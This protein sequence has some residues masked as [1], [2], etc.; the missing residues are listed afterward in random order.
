MIENPYRLV[1]KRLRL[2]G[3]ALSRT[4]GGLASSTITR[5]EQGLYEELSAGMVQPLLDEATR[6]GADLDVIAA[7]LEQR[8]GTPYLH[9][10]YARWRQASRASVGDGAEWPELSELISEVRDDE[11]PMATFARLFAGT[12][13]RFCVALSIP[14]ETLKRYARGRFSYLQPPAAVREALTDARYPEIDKLFEMQ[15]EWIDGGW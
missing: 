8:Y 11:S 3:R 13:D 5:I 14:P 9:E 15:R 1:R 2:S 10:A 7:E 4:E 12:L 6:R